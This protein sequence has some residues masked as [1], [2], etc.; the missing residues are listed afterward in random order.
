MITFEG[1]IFN[2]ITSTAIQQAKLEKLRENNIILPRNIFKTAGTE[3]ASFYIDENIN[4]V[5]EV[6][7]EYSL[8]DLR[9]TDNVLDI[10]SCIGAFSL[11]ICKKVNRVYAIEPLFS[12]ILKKNIELNN[13]KNI[14]VLDIA[15]GDNSP[16]YTSWNG[17]TE[18][19]YGLPLQEIIKL[20]GSHIDFIRCDCEGAEQFIRPTEILNVR[21]IEAEVHN[22]KNLYKFENFES[23]LTYSGF[24]YT[25]KPTNRGTMLMSAKN[26]YIS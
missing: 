15:L 26:R 9:P 2:S 4:T 5:K 21:R 12:D 18:L 6:M 13:V 7:T 16:I 17:K 20:C 14:T 23:L 1:T 10:G 19:R 25:K 24:D 22:F 3:F 8:N 11:N